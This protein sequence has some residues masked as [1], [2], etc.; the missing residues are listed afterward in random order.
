MDISDEAA[1][2]LRAWAAA[3]NAVR[4]LWLFGSRAKGTSRPD[5]D[6]DIALVLAPPEGS[7]DWALGDY[8]CL[9]DEWRAE[10]RSLV[11]GQV[12][13]VAVRDDLDMPFDP[14]ATG[15]QLWPV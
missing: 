8:I 5:S 12:S 10:L 14:R 4:G 15:I 3:Q 6:F 2:R 9:S 13:M 1:E 7:T 11:G